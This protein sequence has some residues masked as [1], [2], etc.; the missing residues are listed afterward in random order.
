M[1]RTAETKLRRLRTVWRGTAARVVKYAADWQL[2]D[3]VR[4]CHA[5]GVTDLADPEL[6]FE[7]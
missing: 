7:A 5:H 1:A 6:P 2:W 4:A 3:E